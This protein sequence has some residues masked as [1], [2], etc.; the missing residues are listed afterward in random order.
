[1][2]DNSRAILAAIGASLVVFIVCALG[3]AIMVVPGLPQNFGGSV[4]YWMVGASLIALGL[5][6]VC[7]VFVYRRPKKFFVSTFCTFKKALTRT[8]PSVPLGRSEPFIV[9]GPYLY[10]R[11]PTYFGAF[12]A[13]AGFAFLLGRTFLLAA[14]LG[15]LIWFNLVVIP[16]E[17]K[18]MKALFGQDYITYTRMVPAF[19]PSARVA[20]KNSKPTRS[21]SRR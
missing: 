4:L 8:K 13:L 9:D 19:I 17:E 11:N 1:M 5:L 12:V 2:N 3:Y 7:W 21:G 18:E 14:A 20:R 6:W 16:Y 10:V 15:L